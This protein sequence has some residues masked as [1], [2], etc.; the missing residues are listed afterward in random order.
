MEPSGSIADCREKTHPPSPGCGE[1]GK[2]Q[3]G[4]FVLR[5]LRV[6][7]AKFQLGFL[8]L[9]RKIMRD[10]G[11]KPRLFR[12]FY[13]GLWKISAS[14][15]LQTTCS[16]MRLFSIKVN[17]GQSRSINPTFATGGCLDA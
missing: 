2:A 16:K 1:T 15:I 6:L 11:L 9:H 13:P 3:K 7:A 10:H 17:Q 12:P 8:I 5:V 14:A 4:R